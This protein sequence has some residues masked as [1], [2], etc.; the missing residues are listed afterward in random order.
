[1]FQ[2]VVRFDRIY[3]EYISC[4]RMGITGQHSESWRHIQPSKCLLQY[5]GDMS[6]I[7]LFSK[8][9]GDVAFPANEANSWTITE[10]A[11]HLDHIMQ[12]VTIKSAAGGQR[13]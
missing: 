8:P 10:T 13:N 11:G 6:F 3:V 7:Q 12:L 4:R 9:V 5:F 1:M 2:H